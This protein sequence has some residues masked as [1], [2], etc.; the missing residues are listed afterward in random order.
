MKYTDSKAEHG[1]FKFRFK[2]YKG[3][4][5]GLPCV[6]RSPNLTGSGLSHFS[7]YHCL[8]FD[9]LLCLVLAHHWTAGSQKALLSQAVNMFKY[10]YDILLLA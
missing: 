5:E 2:G 1:G 7:S 9:V 8:S 10:C 6:S 4:P 3:K